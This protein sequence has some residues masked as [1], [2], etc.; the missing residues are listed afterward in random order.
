MLDEA[1]ERRELGQGDEALAGIDLGFLATFFATCSGGFG[2]LKGPP[3]DQLG[4]GNEGERRKR[5]LADQCVK[6]AMLALRGA[7]VSRRRPW[8]LS[9]S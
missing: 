7:K 4:F 1:L 8:G 6:G 5:E 2:R 9:Q 3:L